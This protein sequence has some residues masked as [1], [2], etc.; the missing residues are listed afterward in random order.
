MLVKYHSQIAL[1][2]FSP[3]PRE[4]TSALWFNLRI[5]LTFN[6]DNLFFFTTEQHRE[7][8]EVIHDLDIWH[9]SAKLV[10]ALTDVIIS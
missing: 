10:K 6:I 4:D 1:N 9:K 5:V 2:F 7:L 3:Q 8:Q